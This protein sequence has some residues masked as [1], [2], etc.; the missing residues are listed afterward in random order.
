MEPKQLETIIALIAGVQTAVVH[1][2][3]VVAHKHGIPLDALADSFERAGE[4]LGME[5]ASRETIIRVLH[6]IAE[7]IRTVNPSGGLIHP[8]PDLLQ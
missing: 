6:Q 3:N 7:G 2:S 4:D 1:L 5:T 8:A